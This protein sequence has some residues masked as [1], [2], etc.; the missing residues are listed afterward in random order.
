MGNLTYAAETE[1]DEFGD[2]R[3]GSVA[4]RATVFM[5]GYI[6]LYLI[7]VPKRSSEDLSEKLQASSLLTFLS[8]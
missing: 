5:L 3:S 1:R 2:C 6:S 7:H 4:A 8:M